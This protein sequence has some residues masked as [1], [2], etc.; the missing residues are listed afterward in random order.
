[1][2]VHPGVK[3]KDELERVFERIDELIKFL[4]DFSVG[5][6]RRRKAGVV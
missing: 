2:E 6:R 3:V 5:Y 4:A 1:M